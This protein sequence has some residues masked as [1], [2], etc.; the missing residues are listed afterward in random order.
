MVI[1]AISVE[2]SIR[3]IA[4]MFDLRFDLANAYLAGTGDVSCLSTPEA[5][6]VAKMWSD[7]TI[8]G[9]VTFSRLSDC[10]L[11]GYIS[12]TPGSLQQKHRMPSSLRLSLCEGM[13]TGSRRI[14]VRS[15]Y[16]GDSPGQSRGRAGERPR[17]RLGP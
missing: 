16:C 10:I 17:I 14:G 4:N 13:L 5:S 9:S 12:N 11:A 1:V 7:A 8:S 3:L 6:L 15:R 2:H